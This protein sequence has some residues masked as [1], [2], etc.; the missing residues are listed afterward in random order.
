MFRKLWN[1]REKKPCTHASQS[2]KPV[3][4]NTTHAT[5]I[6]EAR[7]FHPISSLSI[8]ATAISTRVLRSIASIAKRVLGKAFSWSL[9]NK[10]WTARVKEWRPRPN[11][12]W[13]KVDWILWH[14]QTSQLKSSTFVGLSAMQSYATL[15]DSQNLQVFC[16]IFACANFCVFLCTRILYVNNSNWDEYF[17]FLFCIKPSTFRLKQVGWNDHFVSLTFS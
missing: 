8:R 4:Q 7:Y 9:W 15:M 14:I 3:S 1:W 17:A 12:M 16:L 6:N 11:V 2:V 13:R 10:Y 5:G